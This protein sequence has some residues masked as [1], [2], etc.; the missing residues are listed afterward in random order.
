MKILRKYIW[1][2]TIALNRALF[3]ITEFIN[4]KTWIKTLG[5]LIFICVSLWFVFK[6]ISISE[7]LKLITNLKFNYIL[8]SI[9]F[10]SVS[11]ILSSF[12]LNLYFR[13]GGIFISEFANLRLYLIGMF[14]NFFLPGGIGG[15]GYKVYWLNKNLDVKSGIAVKAVLTDRVNGVSALI[16]LSLIITFLIN[17]PYKTKLTSLIICFFLSIVLLFIIHSLYNSTGRFLISTLLLSLGVQV[18]QIFSAW[19]ILLSLGINSQELSYL[20]LFLISSV[21][22]TLPIS[23]G[24]LGSRELTFLTGAQMLGLDVQVSVSLSMLFYLI[25]LLT[26]LTGIYYI[27]SKKIV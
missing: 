23:I 4:E 5:K 16:L 3:N 19:T 17:L 12:R 18:F 24:G 26:S 14:Y 22:A 7:I 20:W 13:Q 8:I 11:K 1:F 2:S 10:F 21:V 27:I 6:T 25:S 15:D 9:L